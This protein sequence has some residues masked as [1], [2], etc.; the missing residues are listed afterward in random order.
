M[1]NCPYCAELIQD[2]A[3]VCR[4]CG[5]DLVKRRSKNDPLLIEVLEILSKWWVLVIYFLVGQFPV[6]YICKNLLGLDEVWSVGVLLVS[7]FGYYLI[8]NNIR[9]RFMTEKEKNKE[10]EIDRMNENQRGF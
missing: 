9:R 8:A 7:G 3:I 5:R 6:G 10:D 4:Y 2:E 1:K